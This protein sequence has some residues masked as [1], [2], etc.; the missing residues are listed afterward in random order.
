M[1]AQVIQG[2][3]SDAGE[4]RAALA[5]WQQ[6]VAPGAVGWLGSTAGVTDDGQFLAVARF[7]SAESARRNSERLEQDAWWT[8][9]S[10]LFT[11][12]PKFTDSVDVALDIVGNP[13]EAGFV[14]VIQGRTSDPKRAREM[15]SG[16]D[17]GQWAAFRPDVLGSAGIGHENGAYTMV[18]YFTT[19]AE[20]RAGE[21]KELTAEMAAQ[22]E[23]MN[24]LAVGESKYF[25]L[26]RPIIFSPR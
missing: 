5:Q 15:M 4:A 10:K 17:S 7:D 16:D 20:A 18:L 25:D 11:A 13:D 12:E 3:V 19:E 22:M 26:K 9:T 8:Q 1:F 14:Q 24:S 21:S 6:E 23:E 2:P